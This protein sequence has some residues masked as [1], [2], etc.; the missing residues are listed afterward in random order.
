MIEVMVRDGLYIVTLPTA[1][2]VLAKAEFVQALRRG[3]WWRRRQPLNPDSRPRSEPDAAHPCVVKAGVV[4]TSD[5]TPRGNPDR[6]VG[7]LLEERSRRLKALASA[8]R[9]AALA[10][11]LEKGSGASGDRVGE[12]MRF[13]GCAAAAPQAG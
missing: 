2:L 9:G 3:I 6:V 4:R 8:T 5:G 1:I 7:L 12:G 11:R 13:G 10:Q